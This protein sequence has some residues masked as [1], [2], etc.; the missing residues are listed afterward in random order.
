M[1]SIGKLSQIK[2]GHYGKD[3]AGSCMQQADRH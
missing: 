3:T 2:R 1:K